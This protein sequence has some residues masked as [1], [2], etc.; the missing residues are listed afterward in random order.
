VRDTLAELAALIY[1]GS[2]LR[3]YT[4]VVALQAVHHG[5]AKAEGACG[6]SKDSDM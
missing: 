2:S 3:T 4:P 1:D 6:T 5:H